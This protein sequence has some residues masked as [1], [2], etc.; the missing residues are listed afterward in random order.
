MHY[1]L[2]FIGKDGDNVDRTRYISRLSHTD[3]ISELCEGGYM[4]SLVGYRPV[5]INTLM[6]APNKLIE[7]LACGI[8]IIGHTGNEYVAQIVE[9]YQ[10]GFLMNFEELKLYNFRKKMK[11]WECHREN[12]LKAA[13]NLCL[14]TKLANSPLT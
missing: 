11:N 2:P 9:K 3:L 14:A 13:G 8:P 1:E 5:G 6:A 12:A 10:C 7:S 4:Y